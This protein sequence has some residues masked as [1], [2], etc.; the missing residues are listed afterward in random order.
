MMTM[1]RMMGSMP[2]SSM[3]LD[4]AAMQECIEACNACAMAATMCADADGGEGMARCASMCMNM[5]DMAT[6]M[7]R[8]MLR[9]TGHDSAVMTAMLQAC[10]AMCEACAAECEQH[11]EMHEH[12]RVCAMACRN[13]ME[14]CQGMMA[15]LPDGGLRGSGDGYQATGRTLSS[16]PRAE[17]TP[18]TG[19]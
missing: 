2:A 11:A 13:M 4:N 19:W 12:C 17:S 15:K 3:G 10:V 7:M 8:M 18:A 14:A 9:P 16:T 1:T 6:T 5:A